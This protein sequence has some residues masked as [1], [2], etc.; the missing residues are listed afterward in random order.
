MGD[1][2]LTTVR[3]CSG[4]AVGDARAGRNESPWYL[5]SSRGPGNTS[6]KPGDCS[7]IYRNIGYVAEDLTNDLTPAAQAQREEAEAFLEQIERALEACAQA[8]EILTDD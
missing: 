7:R 5:R 6:P 8:Q 4:R 3:C 1:G 2:A